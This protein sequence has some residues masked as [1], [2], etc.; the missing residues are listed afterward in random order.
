MPNNDLLTRL[1]TVRGNYT[2]GLMFCGLL[3][4]P[5]TR[6]AIIAN[7]IFLTPSTTLVFFPGHPVTLPEKEKHIE[8][9][10]QGPEDLSG[11][12]HLIDQFSAMLLRNLILDAFELISDYCERTKQV[13]NMKSQSWHQFARLL[14]NALTHDQCWRFS[15]GD[16]KV[17]PVSWNG[18][19]IDQAMDQ[20]EIRPSFFGWFDGCELFNDMFSFSQSLA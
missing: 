1:E 3:R 15:K 14:R 11:Y 2:I 12:D 8:L 10:L 9:K 16:E 17:L 18:K 5:S 7:R 4:N 13:E 6:P 19:R 20:Q